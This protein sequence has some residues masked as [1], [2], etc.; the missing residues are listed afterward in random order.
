MLWLPL[1][2]TILFRHV[3]EGSL[4]RHSNKRLIIFQPNWPVIIV[5]VT[6]H[7]CDLSLKASFFQDP[8]PDDPL[9]KQAAEFFSKRRQE[10][11]RQVQ[12]AINRG[13]YIDGSY[14][15]ACKGWLNSSSVK[16]TLARISSVTRQE[17]ITEIS[18]RNI[19]DL[20][21]KYIHYPYSSSPVCN[22]SRDLTLPR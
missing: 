18:W 15:P 6:Q 16:K 13:N 17:S 20:P 7:T 9:N 12:L 1:S 22:N 10:F 3:V 4:L 14:F 8:N 19:R 11:E 2:I 5:M 21:L